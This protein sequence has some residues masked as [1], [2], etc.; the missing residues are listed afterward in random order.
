MSTFG[1][2]QAQKA[3]L[4]F[5][6]DVSGI[7]RVH[8]WN[9]DAGQVGTVACVLRGNS[10]LLDGAY[11]EV[12]TIIINTVTYRGGRFWAE[13]RNGVWKTTT[14]LLD[15]PVG[16]YENPTRNAQERFARVADAIAAGLP[17]LE[18]LTDALVSAA[19]WEASNILLAHQQELVKLETARQKLAQVE[20]ETRTTIELVESVIHELEDGITGAHHRHLLAFLEA[21]HS[22][23]DAIAAA[24]ALS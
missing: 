12:K 20:L 18:G 22:F 14:V 6:F 1:T 19:R 11:V 3:E 4:A 10:H 15:S 23:T 5:T 9:L 13:L 8:G 17:E 2:R 21:G 16:A 7:S 24:R